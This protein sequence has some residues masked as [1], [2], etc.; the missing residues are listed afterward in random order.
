MERQTVAKGQ[1]KSGFEA[2][3][4]CVETRLEFRVHYFLPNNCGTSSIVVE[5]GT[6]EEAEFVAAIQYDFPSGTRVLDANPYNIFGLAPTEPRLG[7]FWEVRRRI[8]QGYYDEW[9]LAPEERSRR[10]RQ[11]FKEVAAIFET[12][13][14]HEHLFDTAERLARQFRLAGKTTIS[15]DIT[16]IVDQHPLINLL[17][18]YQQL[19]LVADNVA[20]AP[21]RGDPMEVV[22]PMDNRVGSR[23]L[24][25]TRSHSGAKARGGG[26]ASRCSRRA[27]MST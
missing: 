22:A 10:K 2:V 17:D 18:W 19:K 15:G 13:K 23:V 7:L 6:R 25:E 21:T 4:T 14:G 11:F 1:M 24:R 26:R 9:P 3:F 8:E 5:A 27:L 16:A 12:R 20:K